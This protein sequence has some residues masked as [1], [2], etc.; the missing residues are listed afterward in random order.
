MKNCHL[1]SVNITGFILFAGAEGR[2][3]LKLY[4]RP[5]RGLSL[6]F[7]HILS[8]NRVNQSLFLV[9]EFRVRK[10]FLKVRWF[11]CLLLNDTDGGG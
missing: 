9:N 5:F 7:G 11:G 1:G 3:P 10:I 6:T 4:G 2:S 8:F